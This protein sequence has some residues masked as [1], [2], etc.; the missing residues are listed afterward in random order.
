ML[1]A[2]NGTDALRIAE[3]CVDGKINLILTDV[4]MPLLGGKDLVNR[5]VRLHPEA[6]VLYTSGYMEDV[7]VRE[8]ILEAT[9][10]FLQKPFTPAMLTKYVRETL[11]AGQPQ[12]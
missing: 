7:D 3:E 11:D 2:E 10:Q 5:L 4:V 12:R 6:R 1:E 8:H 9:H